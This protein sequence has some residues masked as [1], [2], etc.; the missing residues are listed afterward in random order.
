MFNPLDLLTTATP[1]PTTLPSQLP[2]DDLTMAIEGL[3]LILVFFL[4]ICVVLY[5]LARIIIGINVPFHVP[6]VF[7]DGCCCCMAVRWC[8]AC[9]NRKT[10]K[11]DDDYDEENATEEERRAYREKV[12]AEVEAG[13]EGVRRDVKMQ[14]EFMNEVFG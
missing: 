10:K 14:E 4:C 7:L 5:A 9:Q 11:M 3:I 2:N 13:R 1:A 6:S 8:V 12:N